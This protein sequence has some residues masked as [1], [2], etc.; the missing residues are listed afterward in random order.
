M[1]KPLSQQIKEAKAWAMEHLQ[2]KS[3]YCKAIEQQVFFNKDGISH[4]LYFR[5]RKSKDKDENG[6]I[7]M[8]MIYDIEDIV[9]KAR[10]HD[11]TEETRGKTN[12]EKAYRLNTEYRYKNKTFLVHVII[13]KDKKGH[14]HYDHGVIKEKRL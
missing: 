6:K 8:S 14:C 2:G 4:S 1:N 3:V 9:K 12:V 7:R 13:F 5:D 11:I 10:L